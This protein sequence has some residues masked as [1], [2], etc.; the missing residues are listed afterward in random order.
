M[1][2][3]VI[4]GA[5]PAGLASAACLARRGIAY[6]LL[7]RGD[8]PAAGLRRVDPAMRLF[9]PARLSR[10]PGMDTAWLGATYPTFG[11]FVAALDRYR[12]V[13]SLVVTTDTQVTAIER[14]ADGFAVR[15]T[16]GG[17]ANTV[18][19]THVINA[20]GIVSAPRLPDDLPPDMNGPVRVMHSLDVRAEHVAAARRLLV[21]GGGA[22]AADVL[23]NWLR[24]RQPDDRA[25]I[26]LRSPLK[27]VPSH[28]FGLD[29][30]YVTWLPEHLPARPLGPRLVARDTMFGLT[31]PRAIRAG[32][33]QRVGGV[34]R[35]APDGVAIIGGETLQPDLLVLAT[36][37][38]PVTAHLGALA[39]V[40][41]GGWPIAHRCRSPR[42]P[43]L[44]FVGARFA[45]TFASPYIR[46]IAR[47][48][49]YVARRIAGDR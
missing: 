20:T 30:H 35:Y 22:S 23:S 47:D 13:L 9:S 24:V 41:A 42:E 37:F 8:A 14:D 38:H 32:M 10:L 12:E 28:L 34:A 11:Q 19:G 33:I 2:H 27:A 18:R 40:D 16:T 36:G 31:V 43:R 46:G 1:S 39:D 3:V 6:T 17:R 4:I 5:G 44:A 29:L 25:W 21:V 7:E 15:C 48:A 26:S 45:R 49:A